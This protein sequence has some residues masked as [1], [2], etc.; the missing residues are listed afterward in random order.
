MDSSAPQLV[1][2]TDYQLAL[3]L[4]INKDIGKS[5]PLARKLFEIIF[6]SYEKGLVEEDLL[7]KVVTL[8]LTEVGL[9]VNATEN[10]NFQLTAADRRI[11]V[12][13]L[14]L[15]SL[16]DSLF[17]LYRTARQIPPELIYHDFLVK[18]T[19]RDSIWPSGYDQMVVLFKKMYSLLDFSEPCDKS[20][21]RWLD[22]YIFQVLP[23]AG[24]FEHAIAV[25]RTNPAVDSVSAVVQLE[26]QQNSRKKEDQEKEL[27]LKEREKAAADRVAAD[28]AKA[29]KKK[30]ERSLKYMSLKQ[31][32]NEHL[33]GA[34]KPTESGDVH[35]TLAMLRARLK[36]LLNL[37][38]KYIEENSVVVS[39][40]VVVAFISAFYL[41]RRRVNL[42]EKL[43]ETLRM[44]FKVTYL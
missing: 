29:E 39:I 12:E 16:L 30:Q 9:L 44:A 41:R 28:N 21:K 14:R 40:V 25:A 35:Q 13:Q 31:I 22:L 3:K 26:S 5:F 18:F 19:C 2:T 43:V 20:L 24:D 23:E 6:H 38:A 11:L 15:G 7:V 42:R 17:R 33:E 1:I 4:F 37:A 8:Y 34:K 27:R 36:L 32:K 10:L